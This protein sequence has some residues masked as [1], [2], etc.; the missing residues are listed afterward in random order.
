M[1]QSN[2]KVNMSEGI[3]GIYKLSLL[4]RVLPIGSHQT[5]LDLLTTLPP[6]LAMSSIC[7]VPNSRAVFLAQNEQKKI[8]RVDNTHHTHSRIN[9]TKAYPTPYEARH[10]LQR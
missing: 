10:R 7:S 2:G 5:L 1:V 4:W 3:L 9:L 6:H 8:T